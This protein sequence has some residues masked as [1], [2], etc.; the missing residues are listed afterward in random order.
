MYGFL[1][2]AWCC[3]WGVDLEQ[4]KPG[5]NPAYRERRGWED[6]FVILSLRSWAP[7][8]GVDNVVRAFARAVQVQP[9]LR[10]MLL[11]N[12]P[13]AKLIHSIVRGYELEDKVL[14]V[15]GGQQRPHFHVPC[16]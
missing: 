15:A 14:S 8:Y 1:R 13:Q 10:L 3:S 9:E 4:F 12:G 5:D 7:I 2:S 6:K 16:C 11:G